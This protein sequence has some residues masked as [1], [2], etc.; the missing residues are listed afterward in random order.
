MDAE[1][2]SDESLP[3]AAIKPGAAFLPTLFAKTD[4]ILFRPIETWVEGRTKRSR[5]DYR[6]TCYRTAEPELLNATLLQLRRIAEQERSNLFF[7]VCPRVGD[8]G[9]FDQAWQIRTVR[10][11]WSDIDHVSVEVARERAAKA[12]LPLPSIIVNSG[13]G[14][15]LYWLLD[16]PF[17][18]NDAG[19]PL[20]VETEWLE[21]SDGRKK[22]RKYIVDDG[23]RVYLDQHRHTSRLSSKAELVQNVL[24]GIAKAVGGDH[25]TDLS[26]LLRIPGTL[27]RKDQRN[28]REPVP[29]V[30][31][32][33][34]P[35][36]RYPLV[37]FDLVKSV[38]LESGRAKQIAAMPLPKRK[39]LTLAKADKL[40]ELI[41]ASGIAE[42]GCRSE[43]DFAIC[44]FAIRNGIA[45]EEVWQQVEHVGKFAQGGR[46]YYDITWENAEYEARA[47]T[48]DKIQKGSNSNKQVPAA[49]S[50]TTT[51]PCKLPA[52]EA[53][54]ETSG[55]RTIVVEPTT[56]PVACTCHQIT[57]HLLS[58][59]N[60]FNRA[61]QLVAIYDEQI[62]AIIAP[63]EL[64]GLLN[65]YVE[66][67]FKGDKAG[68]YKP[69]P[70]AYANTWLN[71]NAERSR[72]PIIKLFTRNPVFTDDWRLVAPGFDARSGIYFAGR[73]VPARISTEH[74][75]AL[76]K[77]FCFKSPADRTNYLGV[78]LT[79][80]LVPRFIGSK[81]AALFNGNQPELGKSIL[82]QI[83]A[84]LRDGQ[85]TETASYNP[86]DEEFEKRL[87]AIVR[88]GITTIIIDNAK[89]HGRNPRIE[90]GCLERS[91]TDS[92]LS[93]R[94][95]GQSASIRA[96]NSHIFCITA[97]SPDVSRDLV[98]RSVVIN[99]FYEGDP[100]R[101]EFSI[102]DPEG[103]ACEHRLELL[104]ELV[105]M[106]ERW[107]AAGMRTAKV[108]SRF[109]KRSWG[110]IIGGILEACGEPDFLANAEEA[111]SLLDE[112]RRE[113]GE[114]IGVLVDHPQGIWTATELADLCS[115]HGLLAADL[116]EGSARSR[117]TKMGT[118]A[119]RFLGEQ[120]PLAV[121]RQATFCRSSDRKGSN[122]RVYVEDDMP[123]LSGSAEPVPNLENETG[124]AP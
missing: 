45:K 106:I 83:I 31:V 114:L 47:T 112:T 17:L 115:N 120:F 104:G 16:E 2:Q 11:L 91:I 89:G 12:G 92:I 36:R 63:S 21:T 55:R 98:T 86:N 49:T 76:L 90:S 3:D 53:N 93:F 117:A 105:G 13:N 79:T 121:S 88:H 35:S 57:D 54:E 5:V 4:T 119:G 10:C 109:N 81:P 44:C 80:I 72:L 34:E 48:L 78:L 75:D 37:A 102:A 68:E 30:L 85:T 28:G 71:H 41:A 32:E 113:F 27:N 61:D 60:C 33:C 123:N 20:P 23:E 38:S 87:G 97:N 24:A 110:A 15:H 18:I 116:G 77:D 8:K 29:T 52:D 107:R 64:S 111:A 69:L 108:S 51:N 94:L 1:R 100:K 42:T 66:F 82:A 62:S 58:A 26:R 84:I 67:Y 25:T 74:L 22:A 50:I 95:L 59:G 14:A 65:Q 101:R 73:V 56:T 19:E 103:H 118:L 70:P 6:N 99:L 9:R 39:K 122:Y 96:E 43:A 124:S 40:A 7:G 46:R